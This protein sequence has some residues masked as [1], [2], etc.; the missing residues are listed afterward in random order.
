MLGFGSYRSGKPVFRPRRSIPELQHNAE[1][2]SGVP[3]VRAPHTAIRRSQASALVFALFTPFLP[4]ALY[5]AAPQP[6]EPA[7]RVEVVRF[8]G[9]LIVDVVDARPEDVVQR[10]GDLLGFEVRIVRE[11][12]RTIT[13]GF[14]G[15]SVEEAVRRVLG[16]ASVAMLYG[17]AEPPA[18]PRLEAV[19]IYGPGGQ[20]GEPPP[21]AARTALAALA[22]RTNRA[23]PHTASTMQRRTVAILSA[24]L[25]SS[26]PRVRA[27]AI[28]ALTSLGTEAATLRLG[29]TVLGDLAPQVRLRAVEALEALG[30]GQARTYLEHAVDDPDLQVSTTAADVLTRLP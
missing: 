20:P 6:T 4:A 10:V 27:D 26:D 22:G 18:P 14:S 30:T 3:P 8:S 17:P 25:R 11:L 19:W 12:G 28:D 13:L 24:D 1:I 5:A 29:E 9:G 7:P 21:S 2:V 23:R 15:L 16:P